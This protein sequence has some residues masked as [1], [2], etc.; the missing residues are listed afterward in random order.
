L[1]RQLKIWETLNLNFFKLKGHV[2]AA[3]VKEN[4]FPIDFGVK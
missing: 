2:I 4:I 3:K 1:S